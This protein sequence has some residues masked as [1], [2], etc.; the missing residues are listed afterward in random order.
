MRKT[1]ALDR[2][3]GSFNCVPYDGPNPVYRHG[4]VH[5]AD[6]GHSLAHADGTPFFWLGDT[7]WNGLIRSQAADWEEYLST[8]RA[9]GYLGH[10][11]LQHP[12]A[13]AGGRS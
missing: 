9:Q 1:P 4:P 3:E 10:P 2:R 5:V 13:G 6:D 8:R 11:V 7:V 12:L